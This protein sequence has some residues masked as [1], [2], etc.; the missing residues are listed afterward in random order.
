VGCALILLAC[1]PQSRHRVLSFIFDGVPPPGSV[2]AREPSV[3]ELMV[4]GQPGVSGPVDPQIQWAS[5]H[6]PYAEERCDACHEGLLTDVIAATDQSRCLGCHGETAL[7]ERWDHGPVAAGQCRICH[8]A[9]VSIHPNLQSQAQ[10]ALCVM[11][12]DAPDLMTAIPA[13]LG[14]ADLSCTACH[15]PHR[16]TAR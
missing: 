1:S 10:P 9:H 6:A 12:H 4:Q 16:S 11:C 5:V 15:D 13:H 8:E 2:E 7:T 3:A 14:Q